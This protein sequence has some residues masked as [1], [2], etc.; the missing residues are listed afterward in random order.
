MKIF[1]ALV[2]LELFSSRRACFNLLINK[3]NTKMHVEQ[4]ELSRWAILTQNVGKA[5]TGFDAGARVIR[6]GNK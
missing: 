1:V 3:L 6:R 5:L 4:V 2:S